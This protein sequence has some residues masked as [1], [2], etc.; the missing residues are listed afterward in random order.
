MRGGRACA[1]SA[2]PKEAGA[3]A[4]SSAGPSPRPALCLRANTHTPPA[5]LAPP[6]LPPGDAES[7]AVVDTAR[8]ASAGLTA[9]RFLF[10]LCLC[11]CAYEVV[12]HGRPMI[13]TFWNLCRA[14]PIPAESKVSPKGAPFSSFSLTDP[15]GLHR[16]A[17]R[18][19]G[20]VRP[21]AAAAA[22]PASTRVWEARLQRAFRVFFMRGPSDRKD[23]GRALA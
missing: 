15:G 14:C 5:P 8:R 20:E 2:A 18:P 19:K 23:A 21:S 17:P 6:S 1:T 9:A 3:V 4:V 22:A 12:A 16:G 13:N 11:W 10:H 7:S